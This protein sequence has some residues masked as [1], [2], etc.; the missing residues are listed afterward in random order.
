MFG[1]VS[2]VPWMLCLSG[3]FGTLDLSTRT[4]IFILTD[5]ADI[6]MRLRFVMA[7]FVY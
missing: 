7:S 2:S 3:V 4:G 1:C 6:L 5:C